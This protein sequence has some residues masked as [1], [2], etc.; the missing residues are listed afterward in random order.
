MGDWKISLVEQRAV[1]LLLKA[2]PEA[3]S[4][5]IVS[6][7]N[8]S[9]TAILLLVCQKW[10]PGGAQ[11]KNQLLEYLLR[12]DPAGSVDSLTMKLLSE[13]PVVAFRL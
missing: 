7:R 12:P 6:T 1:T 4:K 3:F 11:D 5:H 10:Q 13:H 9:T 2:L 8:L